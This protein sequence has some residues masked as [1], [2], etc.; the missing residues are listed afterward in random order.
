MSCNVIAEAITVM[1]YRLY[2]DSVG[3]SLEQLIYIL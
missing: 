2:N 3:Y 1:H